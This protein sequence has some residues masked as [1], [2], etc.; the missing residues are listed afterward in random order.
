MNMRLAGQLTIGFAVPVAA[1]VFLAGVAWFGFARM[2]AAK[3]DLTARYEVRRAVLDMDKLV[4]F[5]S[6]G[7]VLSLK[8]K[9]LQGR[10]AAEAAERADAQFINEHVALLPNSA[11]EAA[12]LSSAI[13]GV[14]KGAIQ[15]DTYVKQDR[16]TALDFTLT[17]RVTPRNA[18]VAEGFRSANE[19]ADSMKVA[20]DKVKADAMSGAAAASTAFDATLTRLRIVVLAIVA[21]TI[22]VT[23]LITLRL[24]RR[25]SGRLGRVSTAL[26]QMVSEDFANL[27]IALDR[28]AQGDL[29]ASFRSE[30]RPIG[31]LRKDE[32][33]D[34]GRSYDSLVAG[35]AKTALE[36]TSGLARLRGLVVE[37]ISAAGELATSSEH[38]SAAVKQSLHSVTGITDAIAR[39]ATGTADQAQKLGDTSV[40]VEELSRTADQIAAV[41][42]NQAQS[43]VASTAA[44]TRLD[45]GIEALSAHGTALAGSAREASREAASGNAAVG[46]TQV[47]LRTLR[48]VSDEAQTTMT[49]LV[50]RS[51]QVEEIVQVIEDIADQTNLLALNAAIE[52]A[53]AG[54]QGRG[55][56][57]VADEVRKL[58][59]RSASATKEI[60]TILSAIRRET[61]GAA[62]AMRRSGES[63]VAGLG[64][65]E[66]AKLALER[67]GTSIGSTTSV[68]DEVAAQAIEMR[69]ASVHVTENMSTNS[70][71]VEQ[72]AAAASEMRSTTSMVTDAIVPVAAAARA[73]SLAAEQAAASTAEL[74]G[75]LAQIEATAR[76]IN[77]QAERLKGL[78]TQFTVEDAPPRALANKPALPRQVVAVR[79]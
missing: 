33:A 17:G 71:A 9:N 47:A 39:V 13:D 57:V 72:N 30:R 19:A 74:A 79:A 64:V 26:A 32:I 29:R 65:A 18:L 34:V 11:T 63:M 1:L 68:A 59:E 40:A 42:A 78:V 3:Q 36:L 51:A 23:F 4:G 75:T 14:A 77:D 49:S 45:A 21:I 73:E 28:M 5:F 76:G 20:L 55:F 66:R 50:E 48:D 8:T 62:D 27:S 16:A 6:R 7:Y 25:M 43:I 12:S 46:E 35:L 31:D 69:D 10:D 38:A 56:A 15:I 2:D 41:A 22:G 52:A 37:V 70:A 60:G 58:A 44:L 53:R 54:E 67:V 24:A 61:V